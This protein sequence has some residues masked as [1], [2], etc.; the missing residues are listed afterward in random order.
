MKF[1]L[2][3]LPSWTPEPI[4]LPLA[5]EGVEVRQVNSASE[6]A[7]DHRPTVLLLDAVARSH[8]TPHALLA[9][10]DAGVAVE[11]LMDFPGH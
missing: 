2:L 6:V 9:L 5:Q 11:A 1:L 10:R 8:F 3:H 4:G 7:A